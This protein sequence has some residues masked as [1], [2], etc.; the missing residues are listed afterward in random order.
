MRKILVKK[1]RKGIHHHSMCL[2][3][4]YY[5]NHIIYKQYLK[6]RIL[7]FDQQAPQKR[8]SNNS[9]SG[10]T[11]HDDGYDNPVLQ[12][13][14]QCM[15]SEN[16]ASAT[17]LVLL[18]GGRRNWRTFPDV[19]QGGARLNHYIS[20]WRRHRLFVQAR[21]CY[22]SRF[23]NDLGFVEGCFSP[24]GG[25]GRPLLWSAKAVHGIIDTS[26]SGRGIAFLSKHGNSPLLGRTS[27]AS[28]RARCIDYTVHRLG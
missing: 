27:D 11:H 23:G 25:N 24:A 5:C 20:L 26:R 18:K 3:L 1:D 13:S 17:S 19:S 4:C 8:A 21:D 12:Q 9:K 16:P 15:P 6:Q 7:Q 10:G 22:H 28:S 2:V 14:I